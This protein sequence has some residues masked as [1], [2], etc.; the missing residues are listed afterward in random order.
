MMFRSLRNR[1]VLSHIILLLVIIPLMGVALIYMLEIRVVLPALERDLVSDAELLVVI[2]RQQKAIWENSLLAQ[3]LLEQSHTNPN[4]QIMFIRPDGRLLASSEPEDAA[5][6][7]HVLDISGLATAQKGRL[8]TQLDNQHLFQGAQVSVFAPVMGADQ[9]I[10]GIV[11]I[12]YRYASLTDE[13]LQLRG[14]IASVLVIALLLGGVL[15]FFLALNVARPVQEVT[16]AIDDLAWGGRRDPLAVQGPDEIKRLLKSV[17][18]LVE[19]L[20]NLE[21][22]R[23]QLLANLVHEIGRP[24]GALRMAI[25]VTRG[26]AK[27]DPQLL[28]ELLAGMDGE[29]ES[30]QRLLD[31]LAH[32]HDQ[33]LGTLEL[34]RQPLAL[35]EWLPTVLR[36]WQEA[37]MSKRLQWEE[38]IPASLPTIDADPVRLA[39]VV[40]NLVSNAIKYTPPG[41]TVRVAAGDQQ[42]SVWIRVSDNGPGIAPEEQGKVFTPFYRGGQGRRI[43]DGMG[44]GLSIA[45]D[46]TLAHGGR[47]ELES[48]PG[49]GSQFT[50]WIPISRE[51]VFS[52]E[53]MEKVAV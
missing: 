33:V 19:R 44:L 46:L 8:V 9:K 25:Q 23:K 2:T 30:L 50:I 43:K 26:G 49:L 35:A 27:H 34:S 20:H 17:N 22:S 10:L 47:L 29:T 12:S 28:D 37:A 7:N 4:K 36:T 21:Q 38:D 39:Q 53:E 40:E 5:Q 51:A 13:L 11:R 15:G 42:Q 16:A 32:L 1:F 31:D 6:V 18:F 52:M 14:L 41:G 48:T 3:A 45:R 24:L